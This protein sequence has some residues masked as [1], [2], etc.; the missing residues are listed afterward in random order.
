MSLL[1]YAYTDEM[2]FAPL[3]TSMRESDLVAGAEQRACSPRSMYSLATAVGV[4]YGYIALSADMLKAWDPGH[5]GGFAKGHPIQTLH[6]QCHARIIYF[7]RREVGIYRFCSF[8]SSHLDLF[9]HKAVMDMEIQFLYGNFTLEDSKLLMEHIQRMASGEAPFFATTLS[10]VY[11]KLVEKAFA[12]PVSS[13]SGLGKSAEVQ[14][15]ADPCPRPQAS[16][17]ISSVPS[18]ST[19]SDAPSSIPQTPTPNPGPEPAPSSTSSSLAWLRCNQC[20]NHVK[21]E[22]LYDGMRCPV[23]PSR[24][25]Q[26]GRPYVHCSVCRAQRVAR[27]NN[28]PNRACLIGF[29]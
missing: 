15:V 22:D 16:I 14:S 17:P 6:H 7:L 12:Q 10:L 8:V 23:C 20:L 18:I 13:G 3:Q 11:D 29:W 5:Q 19:S 28:C 1:S 25:V 26:K 24:S 9:S 27:T 4:S 2:T 21:V